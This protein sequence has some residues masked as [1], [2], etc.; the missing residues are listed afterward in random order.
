MFVDPRKQAS[1]LLYTYMYLDI[2]YSLSL[3]N[4]SMYFLGL[5]RLLVHVHI[6]E[7]YHY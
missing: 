7:Y 3:L 6:C 5:R 1:E 2:V 4:L